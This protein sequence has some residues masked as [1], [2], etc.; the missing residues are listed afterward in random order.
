MSINLGSSG[1]RTG[2]QKV[3]NQVSGYQNSDGDIMLRFSY[4]DPAT[5]KWRFVE[6]NGQKVL[7]E[8]TVIVKGSV[9]PML[10]LANIGSQGAAAVI[11]RA[12]S[13]RMAKEFAASRPSSL[14]DPREAERTS[15]R[16]RRSSTQ[17]SSKK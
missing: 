10:A 11:Q 13:L 4:E 14:D 17:R 16:G 12:E 7:D 2:D 8:L 1:S 6:V 15:A 9:M 5:K 3:Y